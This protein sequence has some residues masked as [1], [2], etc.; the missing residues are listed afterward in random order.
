MPEW[1]KELII[2]L[3]GGAAA[4]IAILTI[5]KSLAIKLFEKAIDT[6]FEKSTLKLT[7]KL[8]RST[9]AYEILLKKEFDYYEKIDP[10]MAE[11]VPLI[12]D[13]V[14]YSTESISDVTIDKKEKYREAIM[15]YLKMIP[16]MKND[17]VMFQPYIPTDI[18]QA[19]SSLL[20]T[21][22]NG[23]EYLAFAGESLYKKQAVEIDIQ[24][25]NEIKD[26]VLDGIALVETHIKTR[27]TELSH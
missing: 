23:M 10:F 17:V 22:Q 7:N 26:N 18:F 24:K 19:V 2:A 4:A 13:L 11:L 16:E 14:Y 15:R 1:I 27:L 12:Q 8:E 3:G 25:M 9:K 5:F 21:M 6:S 20:G